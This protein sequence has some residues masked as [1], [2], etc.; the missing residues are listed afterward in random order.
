VSKPE[1]LLAF[2][3]K[4]ANIRFFREVP[5]VGG[6]KFRF[7]FVCGH[8]DV[9]YEVLVEVQGGIWKKG[10]HST[11]TGIT[12]D[13]EKFSL[14]AAHGYRV[15]PVTPAQIKSGQALMWIEVALGLRPAVSLQ[16]PCRRSPRADP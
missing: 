10:G 12:R 3:L 7:D 11:G 4:A 16:S 8:R 9:K 15:L 2:Q 13:C 6:R 1:D 14:A 5:M